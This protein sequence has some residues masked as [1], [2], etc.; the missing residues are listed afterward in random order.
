MFRLQEREEVEI[1]KERE[2]L[3][4][5]FYEEKKY[6]RTSEGERWETTWRNL[7]NQL[8][9]RNTRNQI[10]DEGNRTHT[11]WA[12]CAGWLKDQNQT[13]SM[14]LLWEHSLMS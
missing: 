10:I 13:Q 14:N 4:R 6:D 7:V 2:Y 11:K 5:L 9:L 1:M 3:T 8:V 12:R